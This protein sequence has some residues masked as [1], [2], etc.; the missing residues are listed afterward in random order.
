MKT[1]LFIAV[2][3]NY[4]QEALN[5]IEH[6]KLG[7]VSIITLPIDCRHCIYHNLEKLSE[8]AQ[9]YSNGIEGDIQILSSSSNISN[10]E[11]KPEKF[12]L[13]QS[14]L[15]NKSLVTQYISAG[16]YLLTPGWLR[17]I[18]SNLLSNAIKFTDKGK[19]ELAVKFN[20]H[21][22]TDNQASIGEFMFSVKDT[23]I[24][25]TPQQQTKLFKAFSQAD[26][27]ITRK[28]G[29]TGLGL[30]ISNKLLEKMGSTLKLT[31]TYGKGS[32]FS[33]SLKKKFYDEISEKNEY[34]KTD[35]CTTENT[36]VG[37]TSDKTERAKTILIA[38]DTHLNM[39]LIK[40]FILKLI[41]GIT[42]F[43]AADGLET[44]ENFKKNKP[45]IIFMDIQMPN[46]NGL[47]AAAQIRAIE[48]QN[49]FTRT[50]II[51]LTAGILNSEKE[52]CFAAGM[53]D[54]LLKPIDFKLLKKTIEKYLTEGKPA[55][56]NIIKTS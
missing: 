31:S 25:I 32:E 24:G 28:F 4:Y 51:A 29:G 48:K 21:P 13:C 38:E 43:E 3:G 45:E 33:F 8:F 5:V 10:N 50:P 49:N 7:D 26:T 55:E 20:K 42:I 54:F 30:V 9:K 18:L 46:I 36:I 39:L 53:D 2:C 34:L 17:Q 44:L 22:E 11:I 27:S 16:N 47:E 19:I 1:K 40:T 35:T 14:L 41:P 56:N 23:G 15:I 6:E 37:Q 52:K 12:Y